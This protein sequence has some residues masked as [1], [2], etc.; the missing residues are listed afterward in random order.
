MDFDTLRDVQLGPRHRGRDRHGQVHRHRQGDRPARLLLQARELRPVHAVPR[1]HRLDVAGDGAHGRRATPRSRR[2]TCCEDVTKQV[3]G[4]TICALGDAAAWPIQ[5]LIRH[6]RPEMERTHP[7][8]ARSSRRARWRRSSSRCPRSTIDGVEV[9]VAGRHHRAAGLRAGRRRDPA[10]LLPRA[11]VDRRQLPHVPGRG[12]AGPPKPQASCALPVAEGM[13]I[14][15]DTPMVQEGAQ[16]R[17][18]I[19]AD[20]P[21]AGLPDLRPGRRVR[22]AGPGDGLWLRPQPLSTRTSA[23]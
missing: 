6:F 13:E 20:Q 15:T 9:E 19:P 17:D 23:R 4:H 22:P 21:P 7:R 14:F 1:R 3:E 11:A 18:G 2:S 10:L 8:R 12:E 16:G 5:G